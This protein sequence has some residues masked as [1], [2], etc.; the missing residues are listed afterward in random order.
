MKNEHLTSEMSPT[1]ARFFTASHRRES[2]LRDLD[3]PPRHIVHA[4]LL[5]GVVVVEGFRGRGPTLDGGSVI[6][7][8]GTE[9]FE[10]SGRPDAVIGDP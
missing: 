9:L 4:E 6:R 7:G 2:V 8:L 1:Q 3:T 10:V 5:F